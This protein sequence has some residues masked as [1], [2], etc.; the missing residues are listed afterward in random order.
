MSDFVVSLI[1]TWVPYAVGAVITFLAAKLGVVI[2]E[3]T[4]ANATLTMVGIV[5]ATYYAVARMLEQKW[6]VLG[7]ILLSGGL[8]AAPV[9]QP[10][11]RPRSM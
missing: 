10:A 2:D 6:P 4:S 3:E 7:R 11:E 1:R 5:T 9:Y 8:A